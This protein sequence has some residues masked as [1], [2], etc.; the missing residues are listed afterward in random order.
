MAWVRHAM[1][2]SALN[3]ASVHPSNCI[4]LTPTGQVFIKFD[5]GTFIKICHENSS[6]VINGHKYEVLNDLSTFHVADGKLGS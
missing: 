3:L 4:N 6:L 1:C 2:E 5:M